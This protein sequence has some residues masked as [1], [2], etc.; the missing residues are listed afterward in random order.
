MKHGNELLAA[1]DRNYQGGRADENDR[2]SVPAVETCLRDVVPPLD[3]DGPS[4]LA[5]FDVWAGY[6]LLDAWLAGTDRHDENWVPCSIK[7]RRDTSLHPL[8]TARPWA[9]RSVRRDTVEWPVMALPCGVGLPKGDADTS[10]DGRP[11]SFSLGRRWIG[12]E[13]S[14]AG[15]GRI[16]SAA[17]RPDQVESV[18]VGAPKQVLS[19]SSRIFC[20][21]L[22]AINRRRLLDGT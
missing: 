4:G 21:E 12:P 13:R 18:L 15:T 2:Y 8:I 9:F 7:R 5:A 16:G 14:D 1:V 11:W 3:R 6:L 17:V 10:S 22:L 20:I 19:E